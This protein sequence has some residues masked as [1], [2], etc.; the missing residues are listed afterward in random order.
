MRCCC[1]LLV[2][3]VVL[4]CYCDS[5]PPPPPLLFHV[6]FRYMKQVGADGKLVGAATPS[7]MRSPSL[8]D[9]QH[10]CL[11]VGGVMGGGS[12]EDVGS[13]VKRVPLDN[14]VIQG[15]VCVCV[16]C[17]GIILATFV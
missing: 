7:S 17:E 13:V 1:C 4:V 2:F 6:L 9:T 14:K 10:S 8:K 12:K 5:P 3:V 11:D 15:I 16:C